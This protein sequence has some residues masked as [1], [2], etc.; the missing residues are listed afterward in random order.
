MCPRGGGGG[1]LIFHIYVGSGH[2]GGFKILN[3]NIFLG[4]SEK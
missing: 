2:F 3:L 4:V 1:S